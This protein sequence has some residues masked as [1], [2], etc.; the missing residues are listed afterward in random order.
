[1]ALTNQWFIIIIETTFHSLSSQ[2]SI[3][4]RLSVDAETNSFEAITILYLFFSEF[5]DTFMVRPC[6]WWRIVDNTPWQH[7]NNLTL[8]LFENQTAV[9][10]FE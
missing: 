8:V 2:Q 3:L 5:V 10:C 4:Y 7:D 6:Y 9:A 1:M